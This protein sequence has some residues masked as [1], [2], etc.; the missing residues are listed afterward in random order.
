MGTTA[1]EDIQSREIDA[2]DDARAVFKYSVLID[3]STPSNS[4]ELSPANGGTEEGN[5]LLSVTNARPAIFVLPADPNDSASVARRLYPITGHYEKVSLNVWRVEVVYEWDKDGSTPVASFDTTG[6]QQK[7]LLSK[8]TV[9]RW[10]KDGA[11]PYSPDFQGLIGV[12]DSSIEGVDIVVPEFRWSEVH[13]MSLR[14]NGVDQSWA[15]MDTL[16]KMTGTVNDQDWRDCKLGEA[17]FLG[18]KGEWIQ[19][20]KLWAITFEFSRQRNRGYGPS[21]QEEYLVVPGVSAQIKKR[22][23]EYLWVRSEQKEFTVSTG[24]HNIKS[25]VSQPSAAYV[26][27]VYDSASFSALGID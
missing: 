24:T 25:L 7:I 18:A 10:P 14:V 26:E 17:L 16:V 12:S 23:H 4:W 15:Y 11:T 21:G 2:G 5:V 13:L 8:A 22:G 3:P 27:R 6:G 1:Y 9:D 19:Q 20:Q